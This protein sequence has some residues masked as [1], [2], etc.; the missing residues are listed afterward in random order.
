M[1]PVVGR[2]NGSFGVFTPPFGI[3]ILP[4]MQTRGT[5][6]IAGL[7][8]AV[9]VAVLGVA[10]CDS[11]SKPFVA[12]DSP[13]TS[14]PVVSSSGSPSP[15]AAPGS[16]GPGTAIDSPSYASSSP[17]VGVT[18]LRSAYPSAAAKEPVAIA[19]VRKFFD[20]MNH[21]IDTG[22]E[23][24]VSALFTTQCI[25]CIDGVAGFKN[26]MDNGDKVRGGHLHLVSIDDAFPSYTQIVRVMVTETEDPTNQ[27]DKAG[28]IIRAYPAAPPTQASFEVDVAK[29]PAVIVLLTRVAS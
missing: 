8:V 21:E 3:G 6:R 23:A 13:Q 9:A 26:M 24:P 11:H 16:S 10:G 7:A 17:I 27:I 2:A 12:T 29:D 1:K 14:A 20:A 18:A 15:S 28:K 19:V 25:Q 4:A 5:H 22:D